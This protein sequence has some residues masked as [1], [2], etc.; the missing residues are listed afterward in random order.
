LQGEDV[1]GH[2][3]EEF[4]FGLG[5][6]RQR[7]E[8]FIA[9]V[10]HEGKI[11]N[12]E[13]ELQHPSGETRN[14]LASV[15]YINLD[16]TDVLIYTFIDI[17]DRVRAEQQVRRLASRLTE[18]EQQERHR[19][20]QVLHDDLQQRLFAIKTQLSFLQ[21]EFEESDQPAFQQD[22]S[23]MKDALANAI[24]ITRNLSI[25]I[26]PIILHGE[27]L[28]DAIHWLS[29]RMQEQYG[30]DVKIKANGVKSV[31]EE[32]LRVALFQAVRELLFNVIKHADILEAEIEFEEL[33]ENIRIVVSDHGKGFNA[34]EIMHDGQG[35]NGLISI[36]HRL[37]LLGCS[38]QITSE[39]GNGARAVIECPKP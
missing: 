38:L 22:L 12:Y 23:E 39:P 20:S 8:D 33:D 1:I 25:D 35:A 2:S 15:Q 11:R 28:V 27:G 3:A 7:R 37:N 24:S 30:L 32:G 36:R 26:S 21:E 19:I 4:N 13:R 31:F 18:A 10:K 16:Q 14:I 9:R 34:Q 6:E 5:P 17:T 29:N